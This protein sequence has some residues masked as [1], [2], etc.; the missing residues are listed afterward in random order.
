MFFGPHTLTDKTPRRIVSLVPSITELLFDLGLEDETAGITKFCV[1]PH[2]W[3]EH[4]RRIGGTKAV[5]IQQLQ[6][7]Q[8]DLILANKEENTRADI[9][10][11][12]KDFPVW[13]TEVRNISDAMDMI[14]DIGRI[15][16]KSDKA[17]ELAATI[18]TKLAAMPASDDPVPTA[19]LIWKDPYMTVGGDTYIHDMLRL[20]GCR[21]L[22][23]GRTRYPAVT[24][25][26]LA[27]SGC[28]LILLSSEPFPFREKHMLELAEA[29]PGTRIVLADGE[30]FSWYGSRLLKAL[31]YLRHFNPQTR[32]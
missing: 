26:D 21:N 5:N 25:K 12:A 19:Y 14:T 23:A 10:L 17:H 18:S 4:K 28:R 16:G 11:L 1:H 20:A 30:M 7:L 22:F 32:V 13:L 29:L 15:T 27:D 24:I 9:E 6:D 3:F 31:D 8:P 2:H